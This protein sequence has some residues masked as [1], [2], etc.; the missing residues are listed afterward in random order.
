MFSVTQFKGKRTLSI[1]IVVEIVKPLFSQIHLGSKAFTGRKSTATLRY[2]YKVHVDNVQ[3]YLVLAYY[4]ILLIMIES[5]RFS[6][7]ME[8]DIYF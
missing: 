7:V 1:R 4:F 6:N 5:N 2:G 3:S 8:S